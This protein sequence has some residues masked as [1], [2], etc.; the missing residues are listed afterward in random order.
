MDT[1][2]ALSLWQ[3]LDL[4]ILFR[5]RLLRWRWIEAKLQIFMSTNVEKHT[6][7]QAEIL[8]VVTNRLNF[9]CDSLSGSPDLWSR[10]FEGWLCF[11]F[12]LNFKLYKSS[13]IRC[14]TGKPNYMLLCTL[15][16]LVGLA[17]TSTIIELVRRQYAQ[18]W[19][20]LQVWSTHLFQYH[21]MS[22]N[23]KP[24]LTILGI[25]RPTC[26]HAATA[27]GISWN[28]NRCH[29]ITQRF[30]TSAHRGLNAATSRMQK[31]WS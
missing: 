9:Q 15:Y 28:W 19:Q 12:T 26:R 18:S 4:E 25:I 2:S 27:R 21:R 24:S 16:I 13:T 22:S 5:V 17:L 20:K 1:T 6:S 10:H 29:S 23:E 8:L 31:E 30:E 11:I 7:V 3:P 14:I